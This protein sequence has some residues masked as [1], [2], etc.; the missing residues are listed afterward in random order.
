M[1]KAVA[2]LRSEV[3]AHIKTEKLP[4]LRRAELAAAKALAPA[5]TVNRVL[6]N[7][8]WADAAPQGKSDAAAGAA[9][10][11]GRS[12]KRTAAAAAAAA[13][14]DNTGSGSSSSS[15]IRLAAGADEAYDAAV[16]AQ[17]H[18]RDSY[19]AELQAQLQRCSSRG[20]SGNNGGSSG[21]WHQQQWQ[22]QQGKDGVQV[23]EVF[24]VDEAEGVLGMV[25]Y[26][27]LHGPVQQLHLHVL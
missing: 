13:A 15:G 8:T 10:G 14:G 3:S 12:K 7:A 2:T 4:L 27:V 23:Q 9:A 18:L 11:H 1:I 22:Q 24:V 6:S 16:A 20:S 17:Q 19:E 26:V 21:G 25:S 5:N